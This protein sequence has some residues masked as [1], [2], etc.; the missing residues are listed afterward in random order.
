MSERQ[1]LLQDERQYQ[2][3]GVVGVE[4]K[5]KNYFSDVPNF[6]WIEISL[7]LNVFLFGFDGTI[8]SSTY[9]TIGNEFKAIDL[10]SWISSSYMIAA[11][12]TLP[13]ATISDILGRRLCISFALVVFS[14][15]CF[16]CSISPNMG[17]LILL[18]AVTGIGGGGL[19]SLS[20]ITNSDII[21]PSKRGLFQAIQNLM[22]GTGAVCGASFG[23]I[24]T[25][26]FGWRWCFGIQV[27]P[28]LFSL[29][30]ALL[31]IPN[32]TET[33]LHSKGVFKID[34]WGSIMMVMSLASQLLVLTI[35]GNEIPWLDWRIAGLSAFLLLCAYL[36]VKIEIHTE[37][38][39]LPLTEYKDTYV[40]L[41]ICLGYFIGV[42]AYTYLFT[43]PLLFQL[44]LGDTVSQAGLR[45]SIPAI[46]TPVGG[47]IA[48]YCMSKFSSF[49]NL[50]LIGTA[51]MAFG[52]FIA[53]AI[54]RDTPNWLNG[55]FLIPANLGQGLV[56]PSSLFTFIYYFSPQKQAASTSTVY[57]MRNIGGVWGISCITTI[58]QAILKSRLSDKLSGLMSEKDIKELVSALLK[59]LDVLENLSLQVKEAIVSEY[60]FAIRVCQFLSG[61]CCVLAFICCFI[62][63]KIRQ[64]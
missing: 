8:T 51:L 38:P 15:G 9:S 59:S 44:N 31:F 10:V 30:V 40:I 26:Y 33:T 11:S 24:L 32:E 58:T 64:V 50:V 4:D 39:I 19:M 20:T 16:G 61:A 25:S 43:L 60:T 42:A 28:S 22:L 62:G 34:I 54:S 53:M 13:L 23:G 21:F 27:I 6:E 7:L 1:S 47:L 63:K 17:I 49:V 57:L 12:T 56:Y 18:R 29:V 52:N 37:N 14:L 5:N 55:I 3:S 36:F 48:G 45:L 41:H 2:E 35:G 46:S